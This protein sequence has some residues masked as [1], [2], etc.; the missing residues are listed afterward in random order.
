[1]VTRCPIRCSSETRRAPLL[2]CPPQAYPVYG[3][4]EDGNEDYEFTFGLAAINTLRAQC[5]SD[6]SGKF[7]GQYPPVTADVVSIYDDECRSR[8]VG[9]Q[10]L[11]TLSFDVPSATDS[12]WESDGIYVIISTAESVGDLKPASDVDI[13]AT[14]YAAD[15]RLVAVRKYDDESGEGSVPWSCDFEDWQTGELIDGELGEDNSTDYLLDG[16]EDYDFDYDDEDSDSA[17][18]PPR[19]KRRT[20]SRKSGDDIVPKVGGRKYLRVEDVAQH[21]HGAAARRRRVTVEDTLSAADRAEILKSLPENYDARAMTFPIPT[22]PMITVPTDQGGCSSCWA[23]AGTTALSWRL[24]LQSKGKYNVIPSQ[25]IAM[26]CGSQ[27][28]DE[29]GESGMVFETA[30]QGYLPAAAAAPYTMTID[31]EDIQFCANR[32]PTAS[33]LRR[34]KSSITYQTKAAATDVGVPDQHVATTTI[35]GIEAAMKE[36]FENGPAGIDIN[37]ENLLSTYPANPSVCNGIQTDRACT[38]SKTPDDRLDDGKSCV[39][40]PNDLNHAVVAVGWG[41]DPKGCPDQGLPGPIKYAPIRVA[42][43]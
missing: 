35:Q 8:V 15:F 29:G 13:N 34:I 39:I 14:G 1:M 40:P 6:P 22:P 16:D 21:A 12:M 32:E 28:C 20:S 37:W 2:V 31:E 36:I 11:I 24:Y 3:P 41:E 42:F 27:S 9:G 38:A 43:G 30:Y 17:S 23:F 4:D 18:V 7:S 33:A 19:K 10:M 26:T 25:Q 5:E